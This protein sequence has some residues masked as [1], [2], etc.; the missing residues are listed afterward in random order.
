MYLVLPGLFHP[1]YCIPRGLEIEIG[2]QHQP[3]VR[4]IAETPRQPDRCVRSDSAFAARDCSDAAP[5]DPHFMRRRR[6]I[7]LHGNEEFLEQD[8]AGM[9]IA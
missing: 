1:S 8:F 5:V 2:L 3:K 9:D 7:E 4:G 6:G